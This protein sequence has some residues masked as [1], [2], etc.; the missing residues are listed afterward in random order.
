MHVPNIYDPQYGTTLNTSKQLSSRQIHNVLMNDVACYY[1]LYFCS[2]LD[3]SH[4]LKLNI[5]KLATPFFYSKYQPFPH[6]GR[7]IFSME[8]STI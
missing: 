3:I 5:P 8:S 2:L 1:V 7:Q 4:L 6:K